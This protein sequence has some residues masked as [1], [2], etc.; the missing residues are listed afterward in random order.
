[1]TSNQKNYWLPILL[2]LFCFLSCKNENKNYNEITE[3]EESQK[4]ITKE[5]RE[6]RGEYLITSMGCHDCHSPKKMSEKGPELDMKLALSGF[7][8]DSELPELSNDALKK[9][10]ML[11]NSDLTAAVG[12]WGVS[13]AANITSHESGIGTWSFDQFKTALTK[14]KFKGQENGRML[15]PPMPWQNFTQLTDEDLKAMFDYLQSTKPINNAVPAPI[16]PNK[17]DSLQQG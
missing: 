1:M 13:F 15:L 16:P 8:Q 17:L 3:E 6:K 2:L 7:K 11:M 5:E 10:W 12:P 9:G 4:E 14:G